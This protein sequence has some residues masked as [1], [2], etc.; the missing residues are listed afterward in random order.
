MEEEKVLRRH[1]PDMFSRMLA[2]V[3]SVLNQDDV[4]E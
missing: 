1:A 4:V 3:Y 2:K